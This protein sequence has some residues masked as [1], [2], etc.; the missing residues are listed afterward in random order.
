MSSYPKTPASV[1]LEAHR[2]LYSLH[3]HPP[4]LFKLWMKGFMSDVHDKTTDPRHVLY[5]HESRVSLMFYPYTRPE[6][7][8]YLINDLSKGLMNA[9]TYQVTSEMCD[10]VSGMYEKTSQH[11]QAID[12]EQLGGIASDC[13]LAWLDTPWMHQ[14]LYGK[15]LSCRAVSWAPVSVRFSYASRNLT[16][17]FGRSLPEPEPSTGLGWRITMWSWPAVD[18]GDYVLE[19]HPE[20]REFLE[21]FGPLVMLHTM[22]W[23]AEVRFSGK[24]DG[25]SPGSDPRSW[26]R[27]LWLMLDSEITVT[28]KATDITKEARKRNQHSKMRFSDVNIVTLRRTKASGLEDF[29]PGHHV[30]DWSCR[31]MV[32]GHWRHVGSYD[33]VSHH[34]YP[35]RDSGDP[36][37]H[38]CGNKIAYVRPYLKGPDHAPLRQTGKT[39]YR[40]S[41]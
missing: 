18:E 27:C 15:S 36:R 26:L 30:V 23:P 24:S 21:Q 22:V 7:A 12:P 6:Q 37:C 2:R 41:R 13:G 8:P 19:K 39:L 29:E 35:S 32:Q 10:A 3:A 33:Q 40:L 34:A 5:G 4:E 9:R 38:R 16:D 28:R 11:I 1:V 20:T 25:G 31:W 17:G 14:D